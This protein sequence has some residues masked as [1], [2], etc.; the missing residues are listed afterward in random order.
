MG[1]G[2]RVDEIA[3]GVRGHG[4]TDRGLHVGEEGELEVDVVAGTEVPVAA[5]KVIPAEVVDLAEVVLVKPETLVAGEAPERRLVGLIRSGEW[6]IRSSTKSQAEWSSQWAAH[7]NP[8]SSTVAPSNSKRSCGHPSTSVGRGNELLASSN[9]WRVFS[10]PMIRSVLAPGL[11]SGD[12]LRDVADVIS[13]IVGI[14]GRRDRLVG[15]RRDSLGDVV[16]DAL[17]RVEDQDTL[18]PT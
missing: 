17:Q 14:D 10:L 2:V 6:M 11:G 13:V 12:V 18:V 16:V 7:S 5:G 4:V 1:V 15:D 9:D 8:C 3:E